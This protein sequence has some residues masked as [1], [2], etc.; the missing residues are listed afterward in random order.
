MDLESHCPLPAAQIVWR[1]APS[2]W[3][4]TLVCKATFRL[5]PG[6][7]PLAGEQEKIH[8]RESHWEDDPARSLLSPSDLVPFKPHAEV[9]LVGNAYAREGQ[10]VS[11]LVARLGVGKVDKSIEVLASRSVSRDGL[12][13]PGK[14]WTKMAL[15]YERAAGGPGT[16]NPAGIWPGGPRDSQGEMRWPNLQPPGF[17]I[18]GPL[19]PPIGFGP[20]AASW[21]ARRSKAPLAASGHDW[22]HAPFGEGFDPGYFLVAPADQQLDSIRPDERITLENLHPRHARLVTRLPGVAPR[23]WVESGGGAGREIGMLADTLWIDTRRSICAVT[24]R[25]NV[26]IEH[27]EAEGRILLTTTTTSTPPRVASRSVAPPPVASLS[28]A[29][30]PVPPPLASPPPAPSPLTALSPAPPPLTALSPA[31]PPLT[32]LSPAPPPDGGSFGALEASNAAARARDAT[33]GHAEPSA[34]S[35]PTP[36]PGTLTAAPVIELIW[37]DASRLDS[38]VDQTVFRD[39]SR[40]ASRDHPRE[41]A[42]EALAH[43][44]VSG[45]GALD[46]ALLAAE[47]ESP[48][49]PAIVLVSGTLELG[50]DEL[51]LLKATTFAA[52]PLA[53]SDRK[54]KE[55][56]DLAA[57]VLRTPV[58]AMPD[59]LEAITARVREAWARA[60]PLLSPDHLATSAERMLIEQRRYQKRELMGETWLRALLGGAG[61]ETP[62]PVYVPE[63]S[64]KSLPIYR[65]FS[66]R[67]IGEVVWQQD[68]LEDHSL[69]L[70][71]L[72]IARLPSR[73]RAR[74]SVIRSARP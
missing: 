42:R 5:E 40:E 9:V 70:R 6:V 43:G 2:R 72:A 63:S 71:A 24:Y 38:L 69:A 66:A 7:A 36:K 4:L 32:A 64:V 14:R 31:P 35:E 23:A 58:P 1:R 34:R 62:L 21:P 56:L 46:S 55:A 8:H 48:P 19:P 33:A 41:R 53:G 16:D 47:V 29:P 67:V 73:A 28:V 37:F 57:E 59:V 12:V 10:P 68:P 15:V 65:R 74:S 52:T 51:E 18:G 54:L 3:A 17:P 22:T 45:A 61:W 50:L 30:P 27:P 13:R 26:D 60:N 25:G 20:I 44:R 49:A 11:S 39:P